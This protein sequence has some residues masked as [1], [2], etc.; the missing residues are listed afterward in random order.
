MEVG[1]AGNTCAPRR[2]VSL[3]CSLLSEETLLTELEVPR[4]AQNSRQHKRF[5]ET[6]LKIRHN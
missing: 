2:L 6:Q 5:I 3:V 1:G 4:A